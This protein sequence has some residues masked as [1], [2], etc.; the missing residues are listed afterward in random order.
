MAQV[1]PRIASGVQQLDVG[2]A[3]ARGYQLRDLAS[4]EDARTLD[5]QIRQQAVK[6]QTTLGDLYRGAV[7]SDGKI[8]RAKI[9][10]GVAQAGY[11][12]DLPDMQK[13]WSDAD[14]AEADYLSKN[15]ERL[16]KTLDLSTKT[17]G[18]LYT[19]PNVT[20]NDVV[21]QI[22]GLV[23][24]GLMDQQQGA[25]F[26]REVPGD[27]RA[28]R[29]YL[30]TKL[31]QSQQAKDMLTAALPQLQAI[32]LGGH[33]QM[34]D[35]NPMTN[36][37]GVGQTLQRSAT[38]GEIETG[39]HNR[40]QEGIAGANLS[41]SRERLAHDKQAPRG[42][43]VT[44]AD[45]GLMLV[46]PRGGTAQPVT[47]PDGQQLA[48][49]MPGQLTPKQIADANGKLQT[50]TQLRMQIKNLKEARDGLG[51]LDYGIVAGRQAVTDTSRSYDG[52]LAALQTTVRQLTR[53][54]GEGAMSDYESRMAQAQL[55]S[56]V[57]PAGVIDQKINQLED[58]ANV[59]ETG[60][61][62]MLNK[63]PGGKPQ[64]GPQ[65]GSAVLDQAKAAIKA[66]APR[67]KVVERLRGMGVDPKGL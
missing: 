27:P 21:Q 60:Y 31:M 5:N 20:A 29:Q 12:A 56:R 64:N 50:I 65:Q 39:R 19:N 17:L 37:G 42:Q 34:V 45:G 38:Q 22:S 57:D 28:L 41:L 8:D 4:R 46:D 47:G 23:S 53:T 32:N 62:G 18:A 36:P 49:K 44:T 15:S 58:L 16:I 24:A 30:Q 67:D 14:K 9:A 54:P 33:T 61:S 11:G 25:Q 3:L 51:D 43:V 52:A 35:T 26:A 7:G 48:G 6:K 1:D 59:I 2:G 66:G 63:A 40:A 13:Q 55:P 10:H